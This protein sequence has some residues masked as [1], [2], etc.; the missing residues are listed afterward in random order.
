[1][2]RV[3]AH[4]GNRERDRQHRESKHNVRW[5]GKNKIARYATK[6]GEVLTAQ[7]KTPLQPKQDEKHCRQQRRADQIKRQGELQFFFLLM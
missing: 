1:M 6:Q 2:C 3:C 4:A 5:H 7:W